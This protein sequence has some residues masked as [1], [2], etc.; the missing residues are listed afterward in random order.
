M[1]EEIEDVKEK[2]AR[3]L[4]G[5]RWGLCA[6]AV[7]RHCLQPFS[8]LARGGV[9]GTLHGLTGVHCRRGRCCV[10]GDVQQADSMLSSLA[11]P[12]A[13]KADHPLVPHKGHGGKA[14]AAAEAAEDDSEEDDEG[15]DS[16]EAGGV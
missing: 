14:A 11:A 6:T 8:P 13:A 10:R 2:K 12:Q 16:G 7:Q 1:I 4:P 15:E 5:A 3:R 9:C